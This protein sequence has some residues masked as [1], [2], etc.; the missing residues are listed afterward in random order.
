MCRYI[1]SIR[2]S[3]SDGGHL[4]FV[5]L[6]HVTGVRKND[7]IIK[8]HLGYILKLIMKKNQLLHDFARNYKWP[9]TIVQTPNSTDFSKYDVIATQTS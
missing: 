1:G 5:E 3:G 9:Y 7:D 6:M 2:F 4:G 8:S